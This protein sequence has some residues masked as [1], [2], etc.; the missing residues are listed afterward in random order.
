MSVR[1]VFTSSGGIV[2][3]LIRAA[4]GGR[5]SHVGLQIG[6]DEYLHTD[7]GGV[8]VQDKQGFLLN[9]ERK[10]IGLYEALPHVDAK[11]NRK[12]ALQCVG[13]P[14]DYDG[15]VGYVPVVFLRRFFGISISNPLADRRQYVCS[16]FASSRDVWDDRGEISEFC[17]AGAEETDP[18]SLHR[19]IARGRSFRRIEP[20]S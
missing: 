3:A 5:A 4:T 18:V 6:P 16:E 8:K 12:R 9:G 20:L 13:R 1:L 2:A 10:I 11:F 7:Q 15:L 17:K 19:R 14:Y